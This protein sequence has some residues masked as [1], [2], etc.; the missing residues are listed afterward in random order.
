[1]RTGACLLVSLLAAGAM[2]TACGGDTTRVESET[3]TT[4]IGQELLDLDRAL[5]RG[6]IS[7]REYERTKEDILRRYER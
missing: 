6:L 3:H 5:D 2:V 1:M 4:T 7:E